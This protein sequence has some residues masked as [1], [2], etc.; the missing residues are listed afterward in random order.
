MENKT[1][2]RYPDT[3]SS[4]LGYYKGMTR[5]EGKLKQENRNRDERWRLFFMEF[6]VFFAILFVFCIFEYCLGFGIFEFYMGF[7]YL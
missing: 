5:A 3:T 2:R 1:K 6:S 7:E 4:R